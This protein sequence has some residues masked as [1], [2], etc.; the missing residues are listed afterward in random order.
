MIERLIFSNFKS[1]AN[2]QFPLGNF[3]CLIGMNGAGKSTLLQAID[4]MSQLMHGRL[5]DWL[6]MRDWEISD[7]S[8]NLRLRQ[9][10]G[11]GI[12]YKT[13]T[14][15]SIFW[16]SALNRNSLHC[17]TENIGIN[18]QLA[19]SV[20]TGTLTTHA[21]FTSKNID[22]PIGFTYQGSILSQ[23]RDD[24][25]PAPILEMRDALR[26]IR[27]LE[28]LAPN[29]MRRPT[30]KAD[31]EK[32]IGAGGEKLSAFLH[33]I[34]GPQRDQLLTL[35]RQF[36]PQV[37][38][39]KITSQKSGWK[40]LS[41]FEQ[42]GDHRIETEARHLNDGLLRVLAILAQTTSDRSLVLL[43]E[44]ENGI[45]QEIVEPLVDALVASPQQT[46]VTTHSPLILNYLSDDTA[47]QAV[48]FIYKT[49]Q[50]ETKVRRFFDIPRINEKLRC[51]GPGD[52]FVDTDLRALTE[53]CIALDA[54]KLPSPQIPGL[55]A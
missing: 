17:A 51:M 29:L 27:S 19:L 44:I 30:S 45:N 38:D 7:L 54:A 14:G 46:I 21:P 47:R 33:G 6:A 32:D 1:L 49:P 41:V 9:P 52:A 16:H 39:F 48:Q 43:D 23:L 25:L 12:R 4:F 35:I 10:I 15:D 18:G 34:K 42:Y 13:Q 22:G 8:S 53:E 11:L 20:K 5:D 55:A 37:T 28:L 3:N 26:N 40:K 31:S 24:A 50:G 36:Y 2:V